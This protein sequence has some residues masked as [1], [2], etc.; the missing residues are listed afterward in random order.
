MEDKVTIEIA[1][2]N[3]S[4]RNALIRVAA[5]V[6]FTFTLLMPALA[7]CITNCR[8]EYDSEVDSCRSQYDDPDDADDLRQCIDNAKDEYDD[9]VHECKS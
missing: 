5:T 9:C 1:Q 8:D 6:G 2:K 3:R 7:G 4:S